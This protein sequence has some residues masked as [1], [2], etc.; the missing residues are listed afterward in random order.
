MKIRNSFVSNSSSSS[1]VIIVHDNNEPCEHCGRKDLDFL[2]VLDNASDFLESSIQYENKEQI[3]ED[4]QAEIDI[5]KDYLKK[6]EGLNNNDICPDEKKWSYHIT[7]GKQKE[8]IYK[9]LRQYRDQR[10]KIEKT[11]DM[12]VRIKIDYHDLI[13]QNMFKQAIDNGTIEIVGD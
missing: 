2:E 7:V 10:N 4:I 6:Y 5:K 3:I 12:I 1:Y 9:I 13:T 8:Y 11:D